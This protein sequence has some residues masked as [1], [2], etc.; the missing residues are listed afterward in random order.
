[1]R[2][3]NSESKVSKEKL[4]EVLREFEL[5]DDINKVARVPVCACTVRVFSLGRKSH[6]QPSLMCL[7][8]TTGNVPVVVVRC[9][10]SHENMCNAGSGDAG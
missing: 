3:E 7:P 9:N 6:H 4:Q 1:M 8:P 2:T 5:D 10:T